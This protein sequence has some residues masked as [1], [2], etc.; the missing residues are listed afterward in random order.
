MKPFLKWAG[1]KYQ[2]IERIKAI[3]PS[4]NRLIEPFIGSGAVFLNTEYSQY[5]LNDSNADLINL[6]K[7]LKIDG[8]YFIKYTSSYF[9]PKYNSETAF[10]E[11]REQFNQTTDT[12]LKSALFVYLNKHAYNG[13][14]R[15]NS[16]GGF[17]VP[18]GRYKKPYFPE[19]EMLFFCEKAKQAEFCIKDFTDIMQAAKPGDVVYCDPPY[20]PLTNTANFTSFTS[21][22]FNL[23]QQKQLALLAQELSRKGIPVIISNHATEFT[24]EHYASAKMISF[25]VQRYISCDGKNRGKAKEI[26]AV[27]N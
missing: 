3:L 19:K 8:H 7:L 18:Y 21:G 17:N 24:D 25:D 22:G 5:I 6:F 14:C 10:Y 20:V 9:Q 11:L 12:Q 16:K 4:G 15:Y 1:N 13:L 26:L 23:E 2:I 27:F